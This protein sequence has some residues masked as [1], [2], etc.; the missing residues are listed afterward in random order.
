MHRTPRRTSLYRLSTV[1]A[2]S[3]SA[4]H[5]QRATAPF[6]A[7]RLTCTGVFPLLAGCGTRILIVSDTR[8][9]G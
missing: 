9:E 3:Y 8:R 5:C 1:E 2:S 6:L 7:T 4:R